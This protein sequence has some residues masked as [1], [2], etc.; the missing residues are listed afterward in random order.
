M[1]KPKPIWRAVHRPIATTEE[2]ME[3]LEPYETRKHTE[4][5]WFE[6]FTDQERRYYQETEEMKR[7]AS[8]NH[9]TKR[10]QQAMSDPLE[11]VKINRLR[12]ELSNSR[13]LTE[14]ENDFH[15]FEVRSSSVWG[16]WSDFEAGSGP[17]KS[18]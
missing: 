11:A 5:N 15:L 13:G 3:S 7:K 1:N 2:L 16:H 14:V 10:Q 9:N 4:T 18:V 17:L 6:R 8:F 12:K